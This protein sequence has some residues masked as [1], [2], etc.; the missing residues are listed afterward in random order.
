MKSLIRVLMVEDN[1]MEADLTQYHLQRANSAN[2]ELAHADC[3][4]AAVEWLGSNQPPDV[5]LLDLHLPDCEGLDGF[6]SL[7]GL[8]PSVPKIIL[9][10]YFDDSL[11][12]QAVREGAQDYLIKKDV[13]APLLEKAIRYAMERYASERALRESEERYALA[14]AGASDGIWDW[15]VHTGQS[16]FS[17]R[18]KEIA[19]FDINADIGFENWLQ[20][21]HPEDEPGFST[22]LK[23]HL[24]EPDEHFEHEIRV[25]SSDGEYRWMLVRGLAVSNGQERAYRMAGSMTDVNERKLAENRLLYDAFH[26]ALTGLP[27]RALFVDRLEQAMYA[28]QR[29]N[30]RRYAVLYFDL[31]RFKNIN[32]SLGHSVGDQLLVSIAR[33]LQGVIRPSDTLSRL[34]GDEFAVLLN[35]VDGEDDAMRVTERV[36]ALLGEEFMIDGNAIYPSASIGI[37]LAARQYGDPEEVIRDADL[38][39][40]RAKAVENR[41]AVIFD[42][43]MHASVLSRL[44]LETDLRRAIDREEFEV[45]YQPIVSLETGQVLSFEALLRWNHPESGLIGP[46]G[47]IEVAEETGMITEL[48]WWVIEQAASQTRQW[49]TLFPTNPLLSV[50]VNVTGSLFREDAVAERLLGLLGTCQLAPEHFHLEITERSFMDH[51][52]VV[53]EELDKLRAAGVQLHI[54]DFGTGYSSL[55]YLQKYSYDTLKIDKSFIS[56]ISNAGEGS[57]IVKAILALGRNLNMNIVA[58][59][60]ENVD[61]VAF[62]RELQCPE[63]QGF[64]FS[65]PLSGPQ[66]S[67]VLAEPMRL[68]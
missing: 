68:N 59:G 31:D 22:A 8:A 25:R 39:M 66:A 34:S 14:V 6:R 43:E 7:H 10:N 64:W 57:A 62:L 50:S 30:N 44:R 16:Y 56:E 21:I 1:P 51:Q 5:V 47:F 29:D 41:D 13:D 18:W 26:D 42:A 53:L 24:A 4:N 61:Q 12:G 40:Y 36:H 3:I 23:A 65:K 60:V 20:H 38:A 48:S 28:F 17:E 54:D 19:G 27:N 37:V 49:Q 55:S 33:R 15:N 46:D 52:V 67:K 58:E 63:A 2:F 32:D 45:H 9:T 35:D 11:A